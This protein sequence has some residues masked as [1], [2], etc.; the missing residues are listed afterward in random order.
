MSTRAQVYMVNS[1]VYL[2]QH[3]D[4]YDLPNI[5]QSA[6][7]RKE[8]WDDEEYLSRIIFSEMIENYIQGPTGYGIGTSQHVDI[9]WLV[10]VNAED[11]EIKVR[12]GYGS[13][14]VVWS[15]SFS[16]FITSDVSDKALVKEV[17]N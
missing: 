13:L 15:G 17:E 16:E 9:E 10:E 4:G 5:V 3:M 1:G 11:Q 2:Y 7:K 14:E 6:L 12:H 8:R